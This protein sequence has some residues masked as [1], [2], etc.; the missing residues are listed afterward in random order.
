M[1]NEIKNPGAKKFFEEGA[2]AMAARA[3]KLSKETGQKASDIP[4]PTISQGQPEFEAWREYFEHHLRWVPYVMQLAIA[5]DQKSM[6]V[7]AQWPQWFD[8]SFQPGRRMREAA[9]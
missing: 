8:A 3:F 4:H 5:D 2:A 1:Q 9:E 7:P 6:T